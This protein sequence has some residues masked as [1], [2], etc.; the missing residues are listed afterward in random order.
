MDVRSLSPLDPLLF[1]PDGWETRWWSVGDVLR[2]VAAGRAVLA[3]LGLPPGAAVAHAAT[4]RPEALVADLAIRAAGLVPAPRAPRADAR[5]LLPGEE[6][7]TAG[8]TVTLPGLDDAPP[9]ELGATLLVPRSDVLYP[10]G[11]R[12]SAATGAARAEALVTAFEGGRRRPIALTVADPSDPE[13]RALVDA[14]LSAGAALYLEYDAEFL[15][16]SALWARPTLIAVKAGEERILSAALAHADPRS[17]RRLMARLETLVLL[18][19]ARLGVDTL[20]EWSEK[21]VRV[22]AP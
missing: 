22:V 19:N 8:P 16:G 1:F 20:A 6:V 7:A 4:H 3:A 9:L 2:R 14:A 13:R 17:R 18:G 15:A 11:E 12:E 21:G 10:S 5:L